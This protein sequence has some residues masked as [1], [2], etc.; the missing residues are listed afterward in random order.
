VIYKNKQ[1][2]TLIEVLVTIFIIGIVVTSV[3]AFFSSGFRN[4]FDSGIRD[5]NISFAANKLEALYELEIFKL[6]DED[7]E[8]KIKGKLQNEINNYDEF[9]YEPIDDLSD[10]Y[11]NPGQN[12]LRSYIEELDFEGEDTGFEDKKY[13]GFK[14][15]LVVFREN[16]D[17]YSEVKTFIRKGQSAD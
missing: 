14:V 13:R 7:I 8:K 5:E 16:R 3:F 10:I 17:N 2:F 12:V 1:G 9:S 6:T 15:I 11:D 4:I